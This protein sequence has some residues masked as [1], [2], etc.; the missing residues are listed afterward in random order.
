MELESKSRQFMI[1]L[2]EAV[3]LKSGQMASLKGK[4]PGTVCWIRDQE[5]SCVMIDVSAPLVLLPWIWL[6]FNSLYG[7]LFIWFFFSSSYFVANL[8]WLRIFLSPRVD[9]SSYC[10][11]ENIGESKQPS[12]FQ[13]VTRHRNHTH[14][15]KERRDFEVENGEQ[16]Y[17][18]G[19]KS[20]WLLEPKSDSSCGFSWLLDDSHDRQGG[21]VLDPLQLPCSFLES[22]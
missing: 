19:E 3:D 22:C 5:S 1:Y 20:F 7:W 13:Q 15:S 14:I 17:L 18:W 21:K 8:F 9:I 2:L 16:I 10:I 11:K 4:D 6:P 12:V